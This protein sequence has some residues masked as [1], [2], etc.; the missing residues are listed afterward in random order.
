MTF[1]FI[2]LNLWFG[3]KLFDSVIEFLNKEKPDVLALQE[4][5]NGKEPGYPKNYRTMEEFS[6]VF[7]YEYFDFAPA[8]IDHRDGLV[9]EQGNAVFSRFPILNSEA[10]FYDIPFDGEFSEEKVNKDFSKTPRNL[11][12]VEL[13]ADGKSM[14]IFNTQGVWG[15]DGEDNPRRLAMSKIIKEKYSGKENVILCGDFN[16]LDQTKSMR[17]FETDL[18]NVFK[19]E[20]KRTFNM[21]HKPENSG[22]ATSVVDMV[23]A[24]PNI[25]VVSHH[26]VDDDV[27]DH[28]PLICEFKI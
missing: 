25:E 20:L 2:C 23:Y 3:G 15:F 26:T 22:F 9:I 5:Y 10:V 1:K 19:E 16:T 28:V 4:V 11:Q 17:A 12:H 8:F 13:D 24:S 14:N 6:K 27:S 18:K 21:R 7:N